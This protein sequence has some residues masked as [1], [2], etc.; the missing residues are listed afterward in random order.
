[1]T[2]CLANTKHKSYIGKWYPEIMYLEVRSA[3]VRVLWIHWQKEA[4]QYVVFDILRI[5]ILTCSS[6]TI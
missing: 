1:M 6:K 3:D 5:E 2:D 4:A